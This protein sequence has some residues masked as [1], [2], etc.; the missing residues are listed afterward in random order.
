MP[1]W[2]ERD[3]TLVSDRGLIAGMVSGDT[4]ARESKS[5]ELLL[6]RMFLLYSLHASLYLICI[7]SFTW[8]TLVWVNLYVNDWLAHIWVRLG[9]WFLWWLVGTW[10]PT[11]AVTWSLQRSPFWLAI[12]QGRQ[13]WRGHVVGGQIMLQIRIKFCGSVRESLDTL[14]PKRHFP[15]VGGKEIQP[16]HSSNEGGKDYEDNSSENGL[17]AFWNGN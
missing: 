10:G 4:H 16:F 7:T 1:G 2:P 8:L 15:L 5:Y 13:L 14:W 3:Q 9:G 17:G 11:E 12:N 6:P